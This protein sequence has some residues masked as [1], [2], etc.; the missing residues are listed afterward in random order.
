MDNITY[1]TNVTRN[2]YIMLSAIYFYLYIYYNYYIG[3]ILFNYIYIIINWFL[4]NLILMLL[5]INYMYY[6]KL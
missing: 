6:F 2:Y 3:H 4:F 1:I 5:H